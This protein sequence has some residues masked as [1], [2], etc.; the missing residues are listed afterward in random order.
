MLEK[1]SITRQVKPFS[2]EKSIDLTVSQKKDHGMRFRRDSQL[3]CRGRH[4]AWRQ[5]LCNKL[6]LY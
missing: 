1:G 4:K 6:Y 2:R 5:K 3:L